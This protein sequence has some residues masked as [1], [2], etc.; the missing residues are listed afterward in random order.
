MAP[1]Y[2]PDVIEK[3]IGSLEYL[4]AVYVVVVVVVVCMSRHIILTNVLEA[5]IGLEELVLDMR[6][7]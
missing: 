1:A 4:A 3:R 2:P 6:R 7:T 5:P